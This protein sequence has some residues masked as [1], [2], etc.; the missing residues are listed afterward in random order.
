MMAIRK[1]MKD[2][3]KAILLEVP[4]DSDFPLRLEKISEQTGLSSLNLLQKWILQEES[5]IG[6]IQ[7]SKEP[8][9]QRAETH[10]SVSKSAEA[11]LPDPSDPKYRKMLI[12][13]AMKLKKGGMTLKKMAETFND[14]KVP[15][16]SGTGKWYA[17]SINNLLSSK[18]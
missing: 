7:R 8:T 6:V 11:V 15:T 17:S 16:V 14:E 2:Q 13:R 4:I 3:S 5:L 10:P 18:K 1:N 12:K 9:P